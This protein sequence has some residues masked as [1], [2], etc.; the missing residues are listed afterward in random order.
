[1]NV[2]KLSK[3][4]SSPSMLQRQR[5][6]AA[7]IFEPIREKHEAMCEMLGVASLRVTQHPEASQRAAML[8]HKPYSA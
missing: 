1:M 5:V 7:E 6:D 2:L 3:L 8:R 4:Q